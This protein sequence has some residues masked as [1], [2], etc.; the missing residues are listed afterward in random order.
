MFQALA[1]SKKEAKNE[2]VKK[3]KQIEIDLS[4]YELIEEIVY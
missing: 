1:I 4:A 3:W 2:L